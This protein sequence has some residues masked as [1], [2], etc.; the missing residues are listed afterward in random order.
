M[1]GFSSRNGVATQKDL[2]LR[3]LHEIYSQDD[4]FCKIVQVRCFSVLLKVSNNERGYVVFH[5]RNWVPIG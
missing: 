4:V 1:V 5:G 3:L 2:K